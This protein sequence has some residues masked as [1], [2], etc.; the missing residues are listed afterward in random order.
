[1]E[2]KEIL[3]EQFNNVIE[4]E[5]ID[6]IIENSSNLTNG[7]SEEF[8]AENILNS[9][10]ESENIFQNQAVIDNL[11]S[12]FLF[13]IKNALILCVEILTICIVIGILQ[14]LAS[15]FKSKSVSDISLLVCNMVI[16]GLAITSLKS[17]YN[18]ALDTVSTMVGTME[19]LM[20]I[21]IAILI[22]TGS[23]MSG[24][25]LS[26]MILGTITGIAFIVKII[27]LPAL[28]TASIL[29][30]IDCL[31]KKYYVN[32]LAKLIRNT[33]VTLMG[34]LLVILTGIINL[35]GLLSDT[36]DGMLLNTVKFSIRSFIPIVGGFTSDTIELFL[37]CMSSIKSVIGIFGIII[38]SL[39]LLVPLIKILIVALIYKITGAL[40]EPIADSKIVEGLT[41][42]GS[43]LISMGAILLFNSLLFIM[44]ITT[45]V[46]L[47]GQ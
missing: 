41:N 37:K 38:I 13:E 9:L 7:L 15:S 32:K 22:S 43:C 8:S 45:I 30:L 10:L 39:L 44:F 40:A 12:L 24:T 18:L 17:T 33:A 4:Q 47:G 27:I 36:S 5:T 31:T 26:P 6:E 46:K 34:F 35:Q 2:Y 20:P 3:K 14:S 21:L 25:I 28:F 19:I 42:M 16:I 29:S 23:V 1:M 11:K